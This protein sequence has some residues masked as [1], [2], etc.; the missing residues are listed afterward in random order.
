MSQASRS[1]KEQFDQ[2]VQ[3]FKLQREFMF[4]IEGEDVVKVKDLLSKAELDVNYIFTI[5]GCES[6]VCF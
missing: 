2:K 5:P 3:Q 6:G 4:A 1:T